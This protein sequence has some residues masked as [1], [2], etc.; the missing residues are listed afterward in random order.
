MVVVDKL[1]KATHFIPVKSTQKAA[2]IA[3]IYMREIAKMHGIPKTIVPDRDSKFTSNFWKGI[4]KEF[5]TNMNFSTTYHPELD[6]QTKRVNRVIEYMLIMH[7]MDNPSKWEDCLHLVEF[8]YN[9]GYQ[10][11]L[12]MIS[13]EAL[14][15]RKCKTQVS[16]DDP[17]NCV[18]VSPELLWKMEENMVKIRLKGYPI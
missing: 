13:F 10:E 18:V 11:S 14:Y 8:Y 5:G 4:F 3:Q 15:G 2:D 17:T 1:H 12:N 7:V 16:W 9:N 6:G